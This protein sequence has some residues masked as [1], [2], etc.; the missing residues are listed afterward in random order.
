METLPPKFVVQASQRSPGFG[1]RLLKERE[2]LIGL[3]PGTTKSIA[4][5]VKFPVMTLTQPSI[6]ELGS[7]LRS[8]SCTLSESLSSSAEIPKFTSSNKTQKNILFICNPKTI[9]N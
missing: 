2:R 5:G 3:E 4:Y 8:M 7:P 9:G 1:L 6:D